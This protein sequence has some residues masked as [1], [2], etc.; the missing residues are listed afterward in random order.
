MNRGTGSVERVAFVSVSDVLG[1]GELVL[2]RLARAAASEIDVT[3]AGGPGSPLLSRAAELGLPVH[4]LALGRKLGR[5]T[6]A[7]NLA[8]Y[9]LA[10]RRLH[11]FLRSAGPGGWTVLQYKWEELLWAGETR[12][13]RVAL[14]EHGPVPQALLR[15]PWARKRVVRAFRSAAA[16]FAWSRVARESVARVSGRSPAMLAAGVEPDRLERALAERDSIRAR[17]GVSG[18]EP[19]LVFAGRVSEEKG[20]VDFL[21][22]LAA[23]GGATGVVCGEGPAPL[24]RAIEGLGLRE[25]VRLLGSVPD[26]LPYLAAGDAM[27]LL[28]RSPGEGRPLAGV[29]AAAVGTPIV[30]AADSAAM[31]H[32][33]DELPVHL[34]DGRDPGTVSE[35]LQRALAAPRRPVSVP[36]WEQAAADFLA[37]LRRGSRAPE[38]GVEEIEAD[39]PPSQRP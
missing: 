25:R 12:P 39:P 18:G 33:A 6:A 11:D 16:L 3:I 35:G 30:A 9:P 24:E 28:S 4:P 8:R 26:A 36:T 10:R 23:T 22:A 19:L 21:R 13:E 14:W 27:V 31:R 38:A 29:E 2:L 1:G 15:L 5:R 17:L 7:S 34:V 20:V 32:L 37:V